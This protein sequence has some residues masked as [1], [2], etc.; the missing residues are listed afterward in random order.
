MRILNTRDAQRQYSKFSMPGFRSGSIIKKLIA[1]MYYLLVLVF[2]VV[3]VARTVSYDFADARDVIVTIIIELF[4]LLVFLTPVIAIGFSDYY[5]WHGIKLFVI[6]MGSICV[7]YTAA[8]YCST[9]VSDDLINSSKPQVSE[10]GT[11]S[12]A[13]KGNSDATI[14]DG[15]IIEENTDTANQSDAE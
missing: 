10:V 2:L 14:I 13:D 5:D 15:E 12:D 3:S 1:C 4:I 6:I 8:V 11:S 9:L 7:F